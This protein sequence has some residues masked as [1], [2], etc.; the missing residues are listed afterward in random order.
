MQKD[1]VFFKTNVL[2]CTSFETISAVTR[3]MFLKR[4][5]FPGAFKHV[6]RQNAFN[7][8]K[9]YQISPPRVHGA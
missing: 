6:R 8:Y 3:S 5:R 4:V 9:F 2:I 1:K 7:S